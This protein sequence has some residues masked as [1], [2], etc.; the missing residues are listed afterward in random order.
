MSER[1]SAPE[2][3]IKQPGYIYFDTINKRGNGIVRAQAGFHANGCAW[4]EHILKITGERPCHNFCQWPEMASEVSTAREFPVTEQEF[5]EQTDYFAKAIEDHPQE[6]VRAEMYI[7]GSHLNEDELPFVTLTKKY[8]KIAEVPSVREIVI[9]ARIT[10]LT[11]EKLDALDELAEKTGTICIISLGIETTNEIILEAARKGISQNSIKRGIEM[12]LTRPNLEVQAYLLVKP[13]VMSEEAALSQ[14]IDDIIFLINSAREYPEGE[15]KLSIN[16][17][18]IFAIKNTGAALNNAYK[19]TSLWSIIEIINRLGMYPEQTLNNVTLFFGLSTETAD[20]KKKVTSCPKCEDALRDIIRQFNETGDISV[21]N[22]VP[23]CDCRVEWEA[24]MANNDVI[25]GSVHYPY[26]EREP[27]SLT[28]FKRQLAGIMEVEEFFPG[29]QATEEEMT[30]RIAKTGGK[31]QS[32]SYHP[33]TGEIVAYCITGK[34]RKSDLE[35]I[36][37]NQRGWDQMQT[38]PISPDGDVLRGISVAEKQGAPKNAGR[39]TIYP[40]LFKVVDEEGLA[41]LTGVSRLPGFSKFKTIVEEKIKRALQP[42]ELKNL[43][44]A[45]SSAH[46]EKFREH[47]NGDNAN[48]DSISINISIGDEDLTIETPIDTGLAFF[49]YMPFTKIGP[50]VNS[51]DDDEDSLG[52]GVYLF[53]E[54]RNPSNLKRKIGNSTHTVLNT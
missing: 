20:V 29:R 13:T 7:G 45:Y 24:E 5:L 3:K 35:N 15:K 12:I 9:E 52:F 28:L 32:I 26:D 37:P 11:D 17:A 27:A 49:G 43:V 22:Q 40:A 6:V 4:R 18:P 33:E 38:I 36:P 23:S 31:F 51:M 25:V 48:Y 1:L 42:E 54:A 47:T 41:G 39:S 19:P 50:V 10:D 14:I 16:M 2:S 44:E 46:I 34:I 53:Y 8:E 21:I 30:E